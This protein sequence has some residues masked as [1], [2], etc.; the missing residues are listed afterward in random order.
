MKYCVVATPF[1]GGRVYG[2]SAMGMPGSETALEEPM[3]RVLGHLL[4]EGVDAKIADDL[5][6]GGTTRQ[7]LQENWRKV[8]EALHKCPLRLSVSKT[9][10][11][12]QSATILGW[13][14]NYG[15]LRASPH[16]IA[17]LASCPEPDIVD[18]MKSFIGAFMVL[19]RFIPGCSSLIAPL[20]NTIAGREF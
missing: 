3:C 6:C 7:E 2:R 17:A 1:R 20:D 14:W 10:I 15:T 16:G 9:N 11:N 5:F 4:E 19:S 18:R 13:I 8:L 12:P